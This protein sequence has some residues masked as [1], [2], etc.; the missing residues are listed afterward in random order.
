MEKK[1]LAGGLA[2]T[3][4]TAV[5]AIVQTIWPEFVI[6]PTWSAVGVTVVGWVVAW[7]K[8]S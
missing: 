6:D 5:V 7:F 4:V 1:V 3:I 2:A 8:R